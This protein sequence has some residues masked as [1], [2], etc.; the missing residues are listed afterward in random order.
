M[1]IQISTL[2]NHPIV[3]N[4]TNTGVPLSG[5]FGGGDLIASNAAVLAKS[6]LTISHTGDPTVNDSGYSVPSFWINTTTNKSYV[7]TDNTANN[8]V[9]KIVNS[10]Y[11]SS[12][13]PIHN[14][15]SD[16]I[17]SGNTAA[18]Q[19]VFNSWD[20]QNQWRPL[21]LEGHG[22]V[23]NS[24]FITPYRGGGS[25]RCDGGF[26]PIRGEE[27]YESASGFGGMGTRLLRKGNFIE[28]MI[29]YQGQGLEI[30][31]T[32]HLQ[33][34]YADVRDGNLNVL[35]TGVA[36][37]P[38]KVGTGLYVRAVDYTPPVEEGDVLPA[39]INTGKIGARSLL[40]SNFHTAIRLGSSQNQNACDNL[41]LGRVQIEYC[42]VGIRCDNE[43]SVNNYF[44]VIRPYSVERVF[45]IRAGGNFYVSHVE[46]NGGTGLT[47]TSCLVYIPYD[48][49]LSPN[50]I[51][52][53]THKIHI[54]DVL[55]DGG[56]TSFRLLHMEDFAGYQGMGQL[57]V[58]SLQ[59]VPLPPTTPNHH[60]PI[61]V[62]HDLY[63]VNIGRAYNLFGQAFELHGNSTVILGGGT[64][65]TGVSPIDLMA[66][67][68]TDG[69]IFHGPLA[70][71]NSSTGLV[72]GAGV[73][74]CSGGNITAQTYTLS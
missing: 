27:E 19:A 68:S 69:K 67:G 58:D 70:V 41:H 60:R 10:N 49:T 57:N 72:Y 40:F 38:N 4:S 16:V 35:P 51:Q 28:P 13:V 47:D 50:G 37:T 43:Q 46:G 48:P 23:V 11:I 20:Y 8:A 64:V 74:S 9:W 65:Y 6:G 33:G 71:Y 1:S 62:Q 63:Q 56:G 39:G 32:L 12:L 7:C 17:A 3:E 24:G 5:I 45:E 15:D 21:D 73:V 59:Y 53:A 26:T 42:N 52:R 22:Y 34:L 14:G 18:I 36:A 61:T 54:G 30:Q 31:G 29:T 66:S 44:E 25:I 55:V 2:N